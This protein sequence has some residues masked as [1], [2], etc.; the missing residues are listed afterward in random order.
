[1]GVQISSVYGSIFL[2]RL[3][4]YRFCF[5]SLHAIFNNDEMNVINTVNFKF[6]LVLLFFNWVSL[7]MLIIK[8]SNF[9][10]II[11]I[12]LASSLIIKYS[13]FSFHQSIWYVPKNHE[14]SQEK[15]EKCSNLI[16]SHN[17]YIDKI[18][19]EHISQGEL[20]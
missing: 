9:S 20:L 4:I 16:K 8:F 1:M 7:G 19:K 17:A 11:S 12:L 2:T 18:E 13:N 6:F 14:T 10:Q 5:P 3:Q 15:W